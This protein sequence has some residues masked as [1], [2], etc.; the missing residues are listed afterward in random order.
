VS[1]TGGNALDSLIAAFAVYG[2][3]GTDRILET[4]DL[5]YLLGACRDEKS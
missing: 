4:E 1:E 5:D 3:R 2:M